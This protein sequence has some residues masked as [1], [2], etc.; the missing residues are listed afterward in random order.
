MLK[1]DPAHWD[2]R[3]YDHPTMGR[4]QV[5]RHVTR[6]RKRRAWLVGWTLVTALAVLVGACAAL[7]ALFS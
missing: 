7:G 2:A 3:L 6:Y 1:F 4:I 5:S